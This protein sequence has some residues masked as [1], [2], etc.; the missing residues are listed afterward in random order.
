V[1]PDKNT[2]RLRYRSHSAV[3]TERLVVT[4]YEA[5]TVAGRV[6]TVIIEVGD[7]DTAERYAVARGLRQWADRIEQECAAEWAAEAQLDLFEGA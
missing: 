3:T 1:N 2:L 7:L 4:G 5:L 6:Q